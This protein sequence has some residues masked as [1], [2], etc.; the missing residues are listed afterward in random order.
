[1]QRLVRQREMNTKKR[2][3]HQNH[4]SL[5][6]SGQVIMAFFLKP[7]GFFC[8]FCSMARHANMAAVQMSRGEWSPLNHDSLDKYLH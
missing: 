3:G 6:L 1:M 8:C 4:L 5:S 2:V 7:L